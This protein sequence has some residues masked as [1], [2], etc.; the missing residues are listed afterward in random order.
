MQLPAR[1]RCN[2][3]VHQKCY[4]VSVIPKGDWYCQP[5][6]Q[7]KMTEEKKSGQ[8]TND[9]PVP[10]A[11]CQLCLKTGGALQQCEDSSWVHVLCAKFT[12]GKSLG[13]LA[14]SA[15]FKY[16]ST[17]GFEVSGASVG[18]GMIRKTAISVD[19]RFEFALSVCR[20]LL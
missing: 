11:T 18:G 4:N 16:S 1:P 7:A 20:I 14:Y 8:K 3:P 10:T 17:E 13:H 19:V 6:A 9:A 5:C 2:I 15:S 12:P